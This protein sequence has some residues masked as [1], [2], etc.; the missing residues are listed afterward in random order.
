MEEQLKEIMAAG[1]AAADPEKAVVRT[2]EVEGNRISA[3]GKTF[4]AERVFILSAGKAAGPMAR[5]AAELLE[6]KLAGGLV[7]TKDD[8]EE[9]PEVLETLYTSHPE[10]D[11]RG[12]EA[13]GKARELAE[14]LEEGD[15]LLALISGGSVCAAG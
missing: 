5:A 1:L 3:G 8:H 15:L 14:S 6:D 9:G 7:V 11:V 10:P 12:V 2:L 4:E 13:T